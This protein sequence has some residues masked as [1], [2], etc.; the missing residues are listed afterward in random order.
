MDNVS[1]IDTVLTLIGISGTQRYRA[2][3]FFLTLLCYCVIWLVNLVIIVIIIVDKSLHEPMYIFLCNMCINTLYGTAGFYPKFLM[4]LLSSSYVISYAGCLLQGFVLH[5]SSSADSTT[6]ALMAYD[7]YVA[8]CRPLVYHSVMTKQRICVLLFFAWLIP[9]Y[10]LLT[11]T[12]TTITSTTR[13]CGSHIPRI[14]CINYWVGE[15]ACQASIT[16]V[17][18]PAFNYTFYITLVLFVIWTYI[19]M[20]KTC[21]KSKENRQK[22]MA[23]CVPHFFCLIIFTFSLFFDLVYIRFSTKH[24]S[25]SV[26]NFLALE[27][28]FF[29]PIINPL[30]YGY[31]LTRIR[32]KITQ[33]LCC[34]HETSRLK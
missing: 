34:K 4:D 5:S 23:T 11:S 19:Y 25:Q 10:L 27:F 28:I 30:I 26:K 32:N 2:T 21:I 8:I 3:L 6:L 29:P 7:R 9:F 31:K 18:I 33:F 14:Y 16:N 1:S 17:I 20:I 22:F 13:I 12:V 15:L 24:I